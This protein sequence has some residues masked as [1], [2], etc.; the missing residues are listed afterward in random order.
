MEGRTAPD[1]ETIQ[2]VRKASIINAERLKF[3]RFASADQ[4]R[5]VAQ[6]QRG[7][8]VP[9]EAHT[10][11]QWEQV[12]RVP[13][14]VQLQALQLLQDAPPVLPLGVGQMVLASLMQPVDCGNNGREKNSSHTF[15]ANSSQ[16]GISQNP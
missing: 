3:R 8:V 10:V 9:P 11:P 2:A 16:G 13:Q 14:V 7:Q 4:L 6:P 15:S 1:W 5:V 12:R